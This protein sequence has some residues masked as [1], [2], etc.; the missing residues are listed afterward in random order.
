MAVI[1]ASAQKHVQFDMM[2]HAA[3][4]RIDDPD[5]ALSC[6]VGLVCVWHCHLLLNSFIFVEGLKRVSRKLTSSVVTHKLGLLAEL[7][8][9]HRDVFPEVL[10]A[11]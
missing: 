3:A 8:L 10:L 2:E 6:A 7:R 4:D 11:L 9:H 5:S 1:A